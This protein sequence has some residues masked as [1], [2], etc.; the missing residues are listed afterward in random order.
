VRVNVSRRRQR[1]GCITVSRPTPK[2]V[3]YLH[4]LMRK[5][6]LTEEEWRESVGLYEYSP[7][8]KRVRS[9]M[10]TR[11]RM[12]VWI[13]HLRQLVTSRESETS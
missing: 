11:Q 4:T 10:I 13:A 5:A 3:E 6:G 7:W 1:H 2:Q 9:E 8:G 12:S